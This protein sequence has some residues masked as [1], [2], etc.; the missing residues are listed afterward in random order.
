MRSVNSLWACVPRFES[1]VFGDLFLRCEV[2][3]SSMVSVPQ[4]ESKVFVFCVQGVR[5]RSSLR[6][7]VPKFG[8]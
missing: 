4:F 2:L 1:E 8:P 7:F 5:L 3:K 6:D